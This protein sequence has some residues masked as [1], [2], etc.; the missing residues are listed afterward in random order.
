[1]DTLEFFV[2]YGLNGFSPFTTISISIEIN[3]NQNMKHEEKFNLIHNEIV[4]KHN[5]NLNNQLGIITDDNIT[6][7]VLTRLN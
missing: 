2:V 7:K 1:M 5:A 4:K 6:I 3:V